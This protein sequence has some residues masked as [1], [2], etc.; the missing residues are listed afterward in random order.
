MQ[1]EINQK[2]AVSVLVE[3]LTDESVARRL[4]SHVG[5][6]TGI[7]Y[8]GKGKAYLL[9]QLAKYNQAAYFKPWFVLVDLDK[10][11]QCASEAVELWLPDAANG[12]RLRIAVHEVE[13]WLMADAESFASYFNVSLGR[14]PQLPDSDLEPKNTLIDIVRHSRKK[15]IRDEIVPRPGSGA[16]VGPLYATR[17]KQYTDV[18]WRPDIAAEHSESL[19]RCIISLKTLL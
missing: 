1:E 5:L 3:G 10:D 19:Q 7:V 13:S 4:I 6:E 8:G 2:I 18:Y 14:I 9:K 12:M 16:K 17:I 11:T 15:S